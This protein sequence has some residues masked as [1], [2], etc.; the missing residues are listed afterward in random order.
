MSADNLT[1]HDVTRNAVMAH[2]ALLAAHYTNDERRHIMAQEELDRLAKIDFS[3]TNAE[4]NF[5]DS[6]LQEGIEIARRSY[7]WPCQQGIL[8]AWGPKLDERLGFARTL[9]EGEA[10]ISDLRTAFGG[11]A[12]EIYLP[13]QQRR[14]RWRAIL[15]RLAPTSLTV[16]VNAAFV[17]VRA[18]W[19]RGRNG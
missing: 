3:A 17:R 12:M 11:Y 1:R 5:V 4:A 2:A 7:P 19:K 18:Q 9:P 14:S 6:L 16:G 10:L 15:N 13:Q 8:N